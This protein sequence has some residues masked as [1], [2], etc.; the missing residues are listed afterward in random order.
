LV[1]KT[2]ILRSLKNKKSYTL[3]SHFALIVFEKKTSASC[4]ATILLYASFWETSWINQKFAF[5][6]SI[7]KKK[8]K[9]QNIFLLYC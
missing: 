1:N 7:L 3:R 2:F 9:S 4:V 6:T 8:N 5:N